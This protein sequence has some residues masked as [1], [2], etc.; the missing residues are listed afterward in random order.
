M[1][2]E[3]GAGLPAG[4]LVSAGC[5]KQLENKLPP[6]GAPAFSRR[7]WKAAA[8]L[9]GCV[10]SGQ[11]AAKW[12]HQRATSPLHANEDVLQQL[13]LGGASRHWPTLGSCVLSH[14]GLALLF[15]TRPAAERPLML[16][17]SSGVTLQSF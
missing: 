11:R 4:W 10:Y 1:R 13:G 3:R 17:L 15:P 7:R 16:L 2:C 9:D 5:L 14:P 6:H 12:P 8:S